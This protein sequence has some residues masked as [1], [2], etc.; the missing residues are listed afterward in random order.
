VPGRVQSLESLGTILRRKN[1]N[2]FRDEVLRGTELC[3]RASPSLQSR[4]APGPPGRIQPMGDGYTSRRRIVT[5]AMAGP[6]MA[7]VR[8]NPL[9]G[10]LTSGKSSRPRSV[11]DDNLMWCSR[12]IHAAFRRT[13]HTRISAATAWQR[14]NSAAGPRRCHRVLRCRNGRSMSWP[15]I[16]L[17]TSLGTDPSPETSAL[18]GWA[19]GRTHAARIRDR[20][21]RSAVALVVRARS[22]WFLIEPTEQQLVS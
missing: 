17:R 10:R 3:S 21:Q 13:P 14:R 19:S 2:N 1:S 22:S 16:F 4:H 8:G 20:D 11:S 5:T 6:A 7:P 12:H 18:K 9:A 15:T